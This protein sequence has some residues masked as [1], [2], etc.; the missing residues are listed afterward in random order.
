MQLFK[1]L[2]LYNAKLSTQVLWWVGDM[3]G[4]M[5]FPIIK[6]ATHHPLYWIALDKTWSNL[7]DPILLDGVCPVPSIQYNWIQ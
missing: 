5:G 2:V 3:E 1:L 4:G 7:L 6:P